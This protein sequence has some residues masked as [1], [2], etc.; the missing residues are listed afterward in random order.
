M[1]IDMTRAFESYIREVLAQSAVM[2]EAGWAAL[3]GNGPGKKPLFDEAPSTNANPDIVVLESIRKEL[4]PAGVVIDVKYKPADKKP[5]REDLNQVIAYGA[6]YRAPR[7]LIVQPSA[8]YSSKHGM[9]LVGRISNLEVY[10]Y[11]FNLD[12]D[13]LGAEEQEFASAVAALGRRAT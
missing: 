13:D 10:L 12:A 6:S 3:D 5:P 4:M 8:E 2:R 11:V 1:I 9:S 7:A